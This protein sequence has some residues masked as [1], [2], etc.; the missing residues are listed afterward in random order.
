M[1]ESGLALIKHE[2]DRIVEATGR[3]VTQ[4]RRRKKYTSSTH[5]SG[6]GITSSSNGG[7]K[8]NS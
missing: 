6:T 4:D 8:D 2:H 3:P 5:S 1:K 7:K